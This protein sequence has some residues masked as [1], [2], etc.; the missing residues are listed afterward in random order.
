M[1]YL[2]KHD[3]L[4]EIKKGSIIVIEQKH[5]KVKYILEATEP[6]IILTYS[7]HDNGY[8]KAVTS[9]P[10]AYVSILNGN[11]WQTR[12]YRR[13][14]AEAPSFILAS[15]TKSN[16]ER[17]CQRVRFATQDERELFNRSVNTYRG[18]MGLW[19]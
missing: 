10:K 8:I 5:S 19:H 17:Y 12:C 3:C 13:P 4:S 7:I 14:Q 2:R 11:V 15:A 1:R 16:Y 6:Q 9:K 18:I